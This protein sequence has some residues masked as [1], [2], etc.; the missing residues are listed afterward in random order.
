[1]LSKWHV[2][3]DDYARQIKES[4]EAE[5]TAVWD[6]DRERGVTWAKSLG[7]EFEPELDALLQREDIDAVVVNAPTNLHREVLTKA[8]NAGKHIFTEKVLTSG[9][10]E[11]QEVRTVVRK[12]GVKFCISYPHKTM[13][14]NLFAKKAVEENLLGEITLV[15]IRNAHGGSVAG[16][17][18]PHFYD[19]A[20]CGG[21]A[22]I[23]LGAHPMYLSRWLLGEPKRISSL[24]VHHY[25]KAVEDNGVCTIE[26]ENK[27]VAIVETGFITAKS[28]FAL[29]L[30]G[31]TGCLLVGGPDQRVKLC[32][33]TDGWTHPVLPE[34]A[35][36]P[37]VHWL[38]GIV[39]NETILYDIDDAY[40][41]TELMEA[42]YLS[43]MEKR[44]VEFKELGGQ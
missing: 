37:I 22:M 43:H 44:I 4:S 11:A 36:L 27:A 42:A 20:A 34:P 1:M 7:V 31:T 14:H 30:Y 24:F 13:P 18:P 33:E 15:R 6:E 23:D 19:K 5:I 21:G 28:P 40:T 26:Y 17:L 9:I 32:T 12:A 16:W 3:A 38:K 35:D 39:R 10:V 8:A 29:E 41:L 2:H 25:G